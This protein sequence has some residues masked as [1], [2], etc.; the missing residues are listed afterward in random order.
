V[1]LPV[2][3]AMVEAS[4]AFDPD[5]ARTAKA[6]YCILAERAEDVMFDEAHAC[7]EGGQSEAEDRIVELLTGIAGGIFYPPKNAGG[8]WI[9]Q[10][11][12]GSLIWGSPDEGV[13]LRWLEDQA[14]RKER[15]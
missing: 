12:Y 11:D 15:R 10:N 13:D 6:F 4:K 7:H 9:W 2:Y 3:R 8:I 1:Q 14:S 5:K